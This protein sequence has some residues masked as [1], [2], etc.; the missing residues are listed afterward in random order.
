STLGGVVCA[1]LVPVLVSTPIGWRMVYFVGIVPLVLLA[2]ARRGLKESRRF[3]EQVAEEDK[4]PAPLGEELLRVFRTPYWK[5]TLQLGLIWFLTYIAS[6]NAITFWKDWAMTERG[7]SDSHAA[8]LITIGAVGAM[9]LV[10]YVGK[11][12]DW[13][14]RKPGAVLIFGLSSAGIV[15]SFNAPTGILL[16]LSVVLGIFAASA[17][18]PVLNAY[19]TELFPTELRGSAYAW[20]N[21]LIGRLGYVMSPFFLGLVADDVG[22]GPTVSF[23]AVFPILATLLILWWLPETRGRELEDTSRV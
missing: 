23:T 14:G 17:G 7:L 19:T 8:G 18:L 11:L 9:P 2:Y 20:S 3:Q 21:T 4:A 10:F 22:W 1:G 12:I 16:Q 5:R 15:G 13:I 6:H